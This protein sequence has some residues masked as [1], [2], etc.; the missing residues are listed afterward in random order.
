MYKSAQLRNELLAPSGSFKQYRLRVS[1]QYVYILA[2]EVFRGQN[3]QREILQF[4]M[5]L[6]AKDE[7]ETVHSRH[8]KIDDDGRNMRFRQCLQCFSAAAVQDG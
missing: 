3:N 4:G 6:D 5:F 1:P 7:L 2:R 8:H